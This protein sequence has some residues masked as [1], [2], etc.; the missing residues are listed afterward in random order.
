M[1]A[2]D[3]ETTPN[4]FMDD[5]EMF[6]IKNIVHTLPP[7]EKKIFLTYVEKGTYAAV[8]KTYNVSVTTACNYLKKIIQKIKDKIDDDN[9]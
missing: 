4:S 5:D 9:T 1:K 8:A 7:P 6:K 2:I 3:E